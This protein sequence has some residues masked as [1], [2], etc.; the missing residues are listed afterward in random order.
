MQWSGRMETQPDG[1]DQV[2]G[3]NVVDQTLLISFFFNNDRRT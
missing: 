2:F 3:I 1:Q